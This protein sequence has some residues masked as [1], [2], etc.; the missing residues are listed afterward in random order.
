MNCRMAP[1]T[2]ALPRQGRPAAAFRDS[3]LFLL[4]RETGGQIAGHDRPEADALLGR[5]HPHVLRRR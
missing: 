5:S 1:S 4:Q 3:D 2:E